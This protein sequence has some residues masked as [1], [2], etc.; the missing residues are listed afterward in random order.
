M[1]LLIAL[2]LRGDR[3]YVDDLDAYIAEHGDGVDP[4]RGINY[5]ALG[6]DRAQRDALAMECWRLDEIAAVART[7]ERRRRG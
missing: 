3:G 5:V 6:L 1:L 4:P 2:P 7:P